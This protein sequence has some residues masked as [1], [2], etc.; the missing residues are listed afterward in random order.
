MIVY[1]VEPAYNEEHER[2]LSVQSCDNQIAFVSA[3]A[4]MKFYEELVDSGLNT[5]LYDF[6]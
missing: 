5:V 2:Y 6:E 1:L 4:T 3:D